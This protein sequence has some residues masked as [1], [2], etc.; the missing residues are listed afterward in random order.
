MNHE[1]ERTALNPSVAA[2]GEQSLTNHGTVY[3]MMLVE[4]MKIL[5]IPTWKINRKTQIS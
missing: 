3:P 1:K 5:L 4:S 2:E